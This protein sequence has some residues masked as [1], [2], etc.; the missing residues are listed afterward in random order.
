M[1]KRTKLITLS[2]IAGATVFVGCVSGSSSNMISAEQLSYRNTA[3]SDESAVMTPG[4]QYSKAAAGSSK[5]IKRAFQDAPPMIPHSVDGM[6][7]ITKNNNQCITCH[8]GIEDIRDRKSGMMKAILKIANKA[9]HKGNDCIVCHGGNP[10]EAKDKNKA[11]LGT[12][13][14]FEFEKG[15][16][17]FYPAPAS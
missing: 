7:P 15:P 4:V 9:G 12:P 17:E 11:H 5:R 2:L 10:T 13:E 1:L 8:K 14:Y 16:K 3:L 6:L